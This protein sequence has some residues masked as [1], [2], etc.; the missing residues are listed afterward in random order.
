MIERIPNPKI[1]VVAIKPTNIIFIE[2]TPLN[3]LLNKKPVAQKSMPRVFKIRLNFSLLRQPG[4]PALKI[5]GPVAFRP[6]ITRG[7]AFRQFFN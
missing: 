6:T 4:Y 2:M 5:T 3:G 7:L 1:N